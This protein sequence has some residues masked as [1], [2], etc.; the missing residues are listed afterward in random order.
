M[1]RILALILTALMCFPLVAGLSSCEQAH[2]HVYSSFWSFDDND[3]WHNCE[4]NCNS[5]ID[6]APHE[7]DEGVVL[8]EAD[9]ETTGIM[10][11]RCRVCG[12]EKAETFEFDPSNGPTTTVRVD[13]MERAFEA[14]SFKNVTMTFYATNSGKFADKKVYYF[15]EN[16]TYWYQEDEDGKIKNEQYDMVTA[17]G[18][19]VYTK[20]EDG[21]WYVESMTKQRFAA[22]YVDYASRF[23]AQYAVFPDNYEKYAYNPIDKQYELFPETIAGNNISYAILRFEAKKLTFFA[24]LRPIGESLDFSTDV[25]GNYQEFTFTNYGSTT[26]K[27]PAN[28]IPK[29]LK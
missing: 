2:E 9:E 19:D 17:S 6:K 10:S 3:H 14:A 8:R 11:Y 26:F 27:K 23:A 21:I 18:Y 25:Y 5:Y 28:A 24:F 20:G 16:G 12:K 13:Q 7:W 15:T 22:K 4:G 29:S 1:K